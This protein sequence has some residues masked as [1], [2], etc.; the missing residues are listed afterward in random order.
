MLR[1]RVLART[2]LASVRSAREIT[3]FRLMVCQRDAAPHA[4]MMASFMPFEVEETTEDG[5]TDDGSQIMTGLLGFVAGA[6]VTG[7]GVTVLR[8]RTP[9]QDEYSEIA[10]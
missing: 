3:Q 10:A 6:A 8:R 7:L 1:S 9:S 5:A 2:V 4:E